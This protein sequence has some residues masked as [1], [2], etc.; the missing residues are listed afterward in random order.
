MK[1]VENGCWV[2]QPGGPTMVGIVI[3]IEMTQSSGG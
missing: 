2:S 1:L 3:P